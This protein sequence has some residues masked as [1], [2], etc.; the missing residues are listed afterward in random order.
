MNPPLP[1]GPRRH[2]RAGL[3]RRLMGGLGL[4]ALLLAGFGIGGGAGRTATAQWLPPASTAPV[5]AQPAPAPEPSPIRTPSLRPPRGG[6]VARLY[7]PKL[8][9]HWIVV[10]GVEPADIKTNPGHYPGT[11]LPGEVGNFAVAGHRTRSAFWDLDRM[12]PGDPIVVETATTFFVYRVTRNHIVS[13]TAWEV[14]AP[15][16]GQLGAQPTEAMLTLT[17]CNPKWDNYE[18]LIVHA[19]LAYGHPREQEL[20]AE[21]P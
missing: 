12:V 20:P 9:K 5:S 8:G 2:H 4:V 11:A 19:R 21:L 18:R 1:A 7:I 6:E 15:V 14:V 17:T 3:G 13:P 16:P 10:E